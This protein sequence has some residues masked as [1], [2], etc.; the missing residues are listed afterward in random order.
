MENRIYLKINSEKTSS[1]QDWIQFSH[2]ILYYVMSG[3]INFL[4]ARQGLDG[5]I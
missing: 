5:T 2:S 4:L 1:N 3:H